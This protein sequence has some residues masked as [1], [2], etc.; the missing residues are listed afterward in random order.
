[1]RSW[2]KFALLGAAASG[3]LLASA[4]G[5]QASARNDVVLNPYTLERSDV[6]DL[7]GP[8]GETYSIMIAWPDGD[9]PSSGWPVLYVLDGED[10]FAAFTVAARRLARAGARS[11]IVPGIVVG[12]SAGPLTRRVRDYTPAIQDYRIPAGKPAAGL[13]TGGAPTFLDFLERSVMPVIATRWRIDRRRETLVG[14]SFG[15]LLGAHAALTRP[16]LFDHVVAVSPSFWFGEG[17]LTRDAATASGAS[18][19]TLLILTGG[20]EDGAVSAAKAFIG[21]LPNGALERVDHIDLPGQTHGATMLAALPQ[22]LSRA[23]G[24]KVP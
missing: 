21:A 1:M 20:R 15:G 16:A 18:R 17:F 10:N 5:A 24:P 7:A 8:A 23:F 6:I 9:P 14:H 3:S 11:G 22:A 4:S 12:I 19:G 13:E 2:M